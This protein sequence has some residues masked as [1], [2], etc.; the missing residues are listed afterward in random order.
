MNMRSTTNSTNP[1]QGWGEAAKR[2]A[3]NGDDA[4]LDPPTP[5]AF[6]DEEWVG[7]REWSGETEGSVDPANPAA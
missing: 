4:L 6:D 2:M 3:A 1:R 7:A 5:T